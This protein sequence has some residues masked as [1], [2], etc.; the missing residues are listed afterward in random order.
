[1]GRRGVPASE[2]HMSCGWAGRTCFGDTG[3]C[4][5]RHDVFFDERQHE[6]LC[7]RTIRR[8]DVVTANIN[9][10]VK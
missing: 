8:V 10:I 3:V 9:K 6:A 4:E 5:R 1:M 2:M 7:E